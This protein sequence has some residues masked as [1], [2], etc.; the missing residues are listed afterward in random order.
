MMKVPPYSEEAEKAILG[1]LLTDSENIY[2]SIAYLDEEDYY[3]PHHK[4][5]FQ[6]IKQLFLQNKAIDILTVSQYLRENNNLEKIQGLTYL[7]HLTESVPTTANFSPYFE[8]IKEKSLRRN[9]I[10][11]AN[12]IISDSYNNSIDIKT[13]IDMVE[14]EILKITEFDYKDKFVILKDLLLNIIEDIEHRMK[15]S[16]QYTGL[17][18]GFNHLDDL[19]SGFQRGNLIVLAARPSMGKT[20]FAI[21]LAAN[22]AFQHDY[23]IG[24]FSL[25]MPAKDLGYKIISQVTKIAFENIKRGNLQYSQMNDLIE[26]IS[27]I[28]VKNL[29][30]DDNSNV[31]V[32]DIKQKARR[33]K[34]KSK[35]DALFIDYLQ[36][37]SPP[38]NTRSENRNV[39]ISEISKGLKILAKELDIP[40]VVLSQL[41]R[42]VEKREDKRPLLSDLRES[43]A[44]EQDADIVAFLHREDYYTKNRKEDANDS[45]H[46]SKSLTELLIQKHRN[47]STGKLLYRFY[48]EYSLFEELEQSAQN[49]D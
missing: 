38:K 28:Y 45:R 35:L 31:S 26:K 24:F 16:I 11:I 36:I 19:T 44:I 47:G 13:I 29:I 34:V 30:F 14:S 9:L 1:I 25:E 27:S 22:M 23:N 32:F 7:T 49:L 41:S 17:Q 10:K 37:I 15:N 40:I 43:G 48:P 5:I 18:T 20:T 42:S 3:L 8:I 2:D 39:I 12:S 33:L 21:N 4:I 6:S 46:G